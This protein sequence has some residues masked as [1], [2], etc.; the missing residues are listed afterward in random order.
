MLP[1]PELIERG[2]S[3]ATERFAAELVRPR[4]GAPAW[5]GFEWQ[6]AR[7]AAVLHGITPLL[8]TTLQWPGPA[9]WRAFALEQRR[10]TLLRHG[11]IAAVL[12]HIDDRASEQGLAVVALKGAALH[13]VGV[14]SAGERPMADI[15]L[16][17][18]PADAQRA[19]DMLATIGY[20]QT[21]MI[22]KHG[23]F[24]PARAGGNAATALPI[25]EHQDNPIK[26]DLHTRITERLPL[27]ETDITEL[28]FPLHPKP[29]FNPY[30]STN[31]LLLHLLLHAAGNM[32]A[33][34]LRLMHLHDIARLAARMSPDEWHELLGT[35]STPTARWWALAPLELVNRYQPGLLPA[36]VLAALR[37]ACPGALGR[38]SR[39]ANLSEMSYA[40]LSIPAFPGLPWCRSLSERRRYVWQRVLPSREHAVSR[41]LIAAEQWA[42]PHP[43]MHMSQG[44]RILHWLFRRPSRQASMYI[45]RAVLDNPLP[46]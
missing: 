20:A 21:W 3:A 37:R 29:G 28:V 33:R 4:S 8:A 32:S 36:Q 45:V 25:G 6:M 18:R 27:A 7:A 42:T 16:L 41:N 35:R 12:K 1:S 10:Q 17:V 44:R 46:T 43:W 34:A 31:A 38:L 23:I 15:D 30:P 2:L 9:S 5:T 40:S 22:W 39:S 13:A 14:Y 19:A 26:I 24:E 11:R